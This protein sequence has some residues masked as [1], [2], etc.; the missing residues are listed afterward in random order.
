[1]KV[2][3]HLVFSASAIFA[4]GLG[5]CAGPG[6]F[7][8]TL[9]PDMVS[10]I[11]TRI[12]I[13]EKAQWSTNVTFRVQER[14]VGFVNADTAKV[15]FHDGYRDSS[16]PQLLIL[17]RTD[18]GRY[19]HDNCGVGMQLSIDHPIAKEFRSNALRRA[20]SKLSV[21]VLTTSSWVQ[22]PGVEVQLRGKGHVYAGNSQ[23]QSTLD[24]GIVPSGEYEVSA[25]RLNFSL[26]HGPYRVT[27][28]PGSCAKLRIRMK[29]VSSISGHLLDA[30]GGPMPNL[31]ISASGMAKTLPGGSVYDLLVGWVQQTVLGKPRSSVS[32]NATTGLD[33]SFHIEGVYPGWY[34]LEAVWNEHSVTYFPNGG[35]WRRATEFSVAE[36][37]SISGIQ[38]RLQE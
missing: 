10:F 5:D 37:K 9:N 36:G 20:P 12:S 23:G 28:L 32:S 25:T 26:P 29:P 33:G 8:A 24:L 11:G 7:C 30:G 14:L 13:D 15:E 21:E 17:T 4:F 31:R 27:L 35:D 34:R 19:L 6:S 3:L 38:F 1:M 16:E 22:I 18:D 2:I